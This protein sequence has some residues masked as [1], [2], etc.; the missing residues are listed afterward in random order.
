MC[1]FYIESQMFYLFAIA[2]LVFAFFGV[3][4]STIKAV[5][6]VLW[7][8]VTEIADIIQAYFYFILAK[9]I[10]LQKQSKVILLIVCANK[11][12][13]ELNGQYTFLWPMHLFGK[14]QL[15]INSQIYCKD[16]T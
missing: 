7:L 14:P 6:N 12:W 8:N 2:S 1:T 5:P 16:K 15:A 10:N 3:Q 11:K 13:L 9:C 4:S